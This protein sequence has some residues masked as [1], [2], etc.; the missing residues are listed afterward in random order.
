MAKSPAEVAAV[1]Q[2]LT[3]AWNS[4]DSTAF[5]GEFAEDGDI[6]NIY[7]MRLRGRAS[8]AGVYDML[9]RSV[10]KRSRI[11]AEISAARTLCSDALMVQ[12]RVAF[13]VPSGNMMGDHDAICSMILQRDG[14]HWRVGSLHNTLVNEGLERSQVA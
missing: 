12:M 11:E 4:G 13:H 6:V 14:R 7:G 8:I 3:R 9:F 1:V 5:A 2:R 10:F